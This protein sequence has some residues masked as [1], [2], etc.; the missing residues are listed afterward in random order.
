MRDHILERLRRSERLFADETTAPV[1]DQGAGRTKT[2]QLW[3]YARDDR[4]WGGNDPPMVAYVYA[5]DR[6]SERAEAHPGDFAGILQVDG[7]GGYAALAKRRQQIQL[8]FC[9]SQ[10]RR[11]FFELA[12]KSPVATE[13]LR[14]IAMFYAIEDEVRG[15]MA[16][17]RRALR[18]ERSRIVIYD[19]RLYLDPRLRQVSAKSKLAEA[20]RYA[21]SRW[22][23][24]TVFLDDGRVE[25]D[26]NTVE[27]SIRPLALNRKNALFAGSDVG[28][29]N[30]VVIATL[31]NC[32]ITGIN[33]HT[34]LTTTLTALANGHPANRVDE[35]MRWTAV[36][37]EHRLRPN[38]SCRVTAQAAV[39][40]GSYPVPKVL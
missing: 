8:A 7:Y 27:R 26:S 35:L 37:C 23:G 33:P 5:A 1:L 28:G 20:I 40:C 22:D 11:K 12:D 21:L 24:L 38:A 10:V 34:W 39:N 16:E 29:D 3:A 25:L 2:G 18:V 14:R 32:K 19:L 36:A 4:P 30:W 9:W 15:S 13:V 31:E 17:Q 6:K